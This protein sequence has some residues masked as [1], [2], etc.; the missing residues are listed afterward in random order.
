MK[1]PRIPH[2]YSTEQEPGTD[3]EIQQFTKDKYGVTFPVFGKLEVNGEGA[4]PLYKW[5][6]GDGGAPVRWNFAKWL[7]VNGQPTERYGHDVA[8]NSLEKDIVQALRKAAAGE[9]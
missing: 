8:P 9:L 2:T 5:L 4:D 3:K 7:V 1:T 6:K